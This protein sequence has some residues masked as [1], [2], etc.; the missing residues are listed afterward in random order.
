MARSISVLC[1]TIVSQAFKVITYGL[2]VDTHNAFLN[3]LTCTVKDFFDTDQL[4]LTVWHISVFNLSRITCVAGT[5]GIVVGTVGG[6][7]H[8]V[9]EVKAIFFS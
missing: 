1:L 4:A 8:I 3:R 2:I 5:V 9:D 7:A 6:D